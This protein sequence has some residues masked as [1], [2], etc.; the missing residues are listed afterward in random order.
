[1]SITPTCLGNASGVPLI[2]HVKKKEDGSWVSPQ[3]VFYHLLGT[4]TL[5]SKHAAS[6]ES[7]SWVYTAGKS[8]DTGKSSIAWQN[9]IKKVSGYDK[10]AYLETKTGKQDHSTPSAKLAEEVLGKGIGRILSYCDRMRWIR[11]VHCT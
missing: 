9:Y 6:F 8:H 7:S 4:A 2:T 11:N 3:S 5:A 10:E 1:M